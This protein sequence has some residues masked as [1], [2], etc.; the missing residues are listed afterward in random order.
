MHTYFSIVVAYLFNF[1]VNNEWNN[2]LVKLRIMKL[3]ISPCNQIGALFLLIVI[4]T[5]FFVMAITIIILSILIF[6][7]TYFQLDVIWI[8]KKNMLIKGWLHIVNLMSTALKSSTSHGNIKWVAM[9][10]IM[11]FEEYFPWMK[12]GYI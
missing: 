12:P 11:E 1:I 5:V 9:A 4:A 7:V 8:E 3:D 6:H 10:R 2:F